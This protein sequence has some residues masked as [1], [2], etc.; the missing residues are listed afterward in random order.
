VAVSA[1]A[2]CNSSSVT[3]TVN[4]V[5]RGSADFSLA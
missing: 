4:D 5:V 1:T 3:L 2:T